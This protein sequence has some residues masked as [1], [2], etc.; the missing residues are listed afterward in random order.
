M[1]SEWRLQGGLHAIFPLSPYPARGGCRPLDGRRESG[2]RVFARGHG[3]LIHYLRSTGSGSEALERYLPGYFFKPRPA[4]AGAPAT[5]GY[6][7]TFTVDTPNAASIAEVVLLRP[8]AVTHGF[9]QSQRF[10]GC[11]ITTV[12]PTS[13]DVK[14]PPDSTV[15]PFGWYLLFL[16]DGGRVPSVA[17]WI[18]VY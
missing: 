14:A 9:N 1:I 6:G 12:G 18:R 13:I 5:T 3:R 15:A 16:V 11:V 17:R 4:I 2:S 7:A 10:I 8:G